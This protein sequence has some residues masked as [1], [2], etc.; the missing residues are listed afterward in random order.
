MQVC[1]PFRVSLL[2]ILISSFHFILQV[3][4]QQENKVCL[5]HIDPYDL[6]VCFFTFIYLRALQIGQTPAMAADPDRFEVLPDVYFL[7]S[8]QVSLWLAFLQV[9]FSLFFSAF[10]FI[11]RFYQSNIP[12]FAFR[13]TFSFFIFIQ[14]SRPSE[15]GLRSI[16]LVVLV[17]LILFTGLLR[18][19]L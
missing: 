19:E 10:S 8:A 13:L 9:C 2:I 1:I 5:F 16:A 17:L 6:F 7:I 12:R 14:I 3:T 4:Q 11:C 15:I 18:K